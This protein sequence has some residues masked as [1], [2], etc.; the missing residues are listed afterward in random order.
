MAV[1]LSCHLSGHLPGC[2]GQCENLELKYAS[3]ETAP[4]HEKSESWTK[5]RYIADISGSGFPHKF[6]LKC[7]LSGLKLLSLGGDSSRSSVI[8][9]SCQNM[10][11]SLLL[12][13]S[14]QAGSLVPAPS[15]LLWEQIHRKMP[16]GP[17]IYRHTLP[18]VPASQQEEHTVVFHTSPPF[19]PLSSAEFRGN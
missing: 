8:S 17:P 4:E 16:S 18:G 15:Q 14:N 3:E 9:Q 10:P 13:T 1:Y 2:K 7:Q 5:S 6:A 11:C 19:S 12:N